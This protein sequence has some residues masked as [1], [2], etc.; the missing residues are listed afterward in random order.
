MAVASVHLGGVLLVKTIFW[1]PN[2]M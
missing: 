1:T 2:W